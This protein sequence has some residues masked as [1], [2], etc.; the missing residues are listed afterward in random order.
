MAIPSARRP[1]ALPIRGDTPGFGRC[2]CRSR[3]T[4][5]PMS[6]PCASSGTP[7]RTRGRRVGGCWRVG[8]EGT[9][10]ERSERRER[11]RWIQKKPGRARRR[12]IR[13]LAPYLTWR[14][15]AANHHDF[16]CLRQSTRASA[17]RQAP[18]RPLPHPDFEFAAASSPCVMGAW[19]CDRG[20]SRQGR[21]RVPSLPR[22]ERRI[23]PPAPRARLAAGLGE[24]YISRIVVDPTPT[25][26][27]I[28]PTRPPGDLTVM[29]R[30]GVVAFHQSDA[31]APLRVHR[32]AELHAAPLMA[33]DFN[34]EAHS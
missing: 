25:R 17:C 4:C 28:R 15:E 3:H 23:A 1:A 26:R 22:P 31:L 18:R 7:R 6:R 10:A 19:P 27:P 24:P 21:S 32:V 16:S 12:A 13:F 8:S 33:P 5:I 34:Q 9:L 2:T 11:E 29:T 30:S 14:Q 20:A